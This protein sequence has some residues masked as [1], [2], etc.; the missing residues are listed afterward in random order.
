MLSASAAWQ[1]ISVW[2]KLAEKVAADVFAAF[3]NEQLSNLAARLSVS[4]NLSDD[5]EIQALNKQWRGKDRPTNVL[6]FPMLAA[7]EIEALAGG[8]MDDIMP[9]EIMLGDII[10][11]YETCAAEAKEK[12]I[13]LEQHAAH[14]IVHGMLHLLGH[15]HKEDAQAEMMEAL[16][17]KALASMGLPN[18]YR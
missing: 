18:P 7:A 14:L 15:D 4:I 9:H 13:S 2:E 1:D 5:A 16:E 11:A 10:L 3:E 17:I 6:S 12:S 8:R